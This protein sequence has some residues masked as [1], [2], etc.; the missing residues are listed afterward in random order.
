LA[1]AKKTAAGKITIAEQIGGE[2][3]GSHSDDDRPPHGRAECHQET[4][5]DARGQPEHCDTV[6]LV[7]Q[8]QAE[9]CGK[10][11]QDRDGDRCGTLSPRRR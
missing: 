1:T 9:T 8:R 6:H 7:D 2:G 3:G 11:E 10:K 4:G 5:S